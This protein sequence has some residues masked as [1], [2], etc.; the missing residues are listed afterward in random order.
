LESIKD[1][2]KFLGARQTIFILKMES[3][4]ATSFAG[5]DLIFLHTDLLMI[6]FSLAIEFPAI[7]AEISAFLAL[8]I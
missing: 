3:F 2:E 1:F 5:L 7:F 4:H 6:D 8:A